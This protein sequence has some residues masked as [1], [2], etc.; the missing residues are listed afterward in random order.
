MSGSD[1]SYVRVWDVE[2]GHCEQSFM[3]TQPKIVRSVAI[4][5]DHCVSG[6]DDGKVTPRPATHATWNVI[7]SVLKAG[8]S[9]RKC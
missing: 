1:D 3:H 7:F 9:I 5:G 6:A 2:T 4:D 8:F